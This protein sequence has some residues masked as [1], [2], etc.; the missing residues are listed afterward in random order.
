VSQAVAGEIDA[1]GVVLDAV[2]DGVG[3]GGAADQVVDL[4]RR[5]A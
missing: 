1:V 2:E 5:Y 4:R 3:V